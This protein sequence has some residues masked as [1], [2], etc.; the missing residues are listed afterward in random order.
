MTK[1]TLYP[2]SNV[3]ILSTAPQWA[4]GANAPPVYPGPVNPTPPKNPEVLQTGQPGTP[5]IQIEQTKEIAASTSADKAPEER[6]PPNDN[7]IEEPG[8]NEPDQIEE[9]APSDAPELPL[10]IQIAL[11]ERAAR[12]VGA[13]RSLPAVAGP[14]WGKKPEIDLSHHAARCSICN[15]PDRDAIEQGYLHWENPTYL[16]YEYG[17]GQRRA[18]YRHARALGLREKRGERT[19]R[20]LEFVIEQAENTTATAD[21]VIRAVRAYSCLSEDGRWTEPTKRVIITHEHVDRVAG[22]ASSSQNDVQQEGFE[23][24]PA[25]SPEPLA[26][27]NATLGDGHTMPSE[28]PVSRAAPTKVQKLMDTLFTGF[29]R[30]FS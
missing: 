26:S 25:S 30:R 10:P 7:M 8:F 17:L 2:G 4:F 1:S 3:R 11:E 12:D 16:A 15:H 18:V 5:E 19:R 6:R 28:N 27:R 13:G 22:H 9:E 29:Q 24:F 21:S 20:S 14:A 23:P